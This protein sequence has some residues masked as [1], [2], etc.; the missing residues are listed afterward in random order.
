LTEDTAGNLDEESLSLGPIQA[1]G[2][3]PSRISVD[4]DARLYVFQEFVPGIC[5]VASGL[6][7]SRHR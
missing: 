5:R 1:C 6:S 4:T 2:L 7:G 3:K